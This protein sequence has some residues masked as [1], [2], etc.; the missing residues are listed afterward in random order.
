MSDTASDLA[1]GDLSEARI[2]AA[3]RATELFRDLPDAAVDA[4]AAAAVEKRVRAGEAVFTVGQHDGAEFHL[5]VKGRVRVAKPGDG[6]EMLIER[7]V[8]GSLFGLAGA[9]ADWTS[10]ADHQATMTAEIDTE[11]ACID[12]AA[13]REVIAQRPSLARTLMLHF[14][15]AVAAGPSLH[16]DDGAPE[17]RIFAALLKEVE[18]DP[19][20]GDWKVPRMPKH[21]ELAERAGADESTVANAV[22][23]LIN[24]G[25]ARR[26]YPGL[27]IVDMA[28]LNRLAS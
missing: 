15:R 9:V 21:R 13:F 18:R 17:R 8:E 19:L 12:A 22:A 1:S 2:A 6:G 3:L 23:R 20:S 10:P 24:D 28:R 25:A 4:V 11:I 7:F 5:V 27:V 26:D 14:A 16:R